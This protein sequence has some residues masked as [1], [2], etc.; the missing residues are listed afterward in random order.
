M[1]D[2][3]PAVAERAGYYAERLRERLGFG[4]RWLAEQVSLWMSPQRVTESVWSSTPAGTGCGHDRELNAP[5][6]VQ[7]HLGVRLRA[8]RRP[9]ALPETEIWDHGRVSVVKAPAGLGSAGR[10]LWRSVTADF[11]LAGHEVLILAEACRTSDVC[12]ELARV[13]ARDGPLLEGPRLHPACRELRQQRIT[14]AR[15]VTCLRIPA[16]DDAD[17]G[18][19]RGFRGAYGVKSA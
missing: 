19:Y 12:A 16:D 15:L 11:E 3:A 10:R 9:R 13:V 14:L 7:D 2:Q 1:P 4:P 8:V 17:R 5:D 18:Q 6:S